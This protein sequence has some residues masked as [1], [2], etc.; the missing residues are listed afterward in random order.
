MFV[1][2]VFLRG[3]EKYKL[4]CRRKGKEKDYSPSLASKAVRNANPFTFLLINLNSSLGHRA[5]M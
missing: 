2:K 5:C 3:E 4:E 1:S